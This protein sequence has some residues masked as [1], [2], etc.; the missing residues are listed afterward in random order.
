MP[1]GSRTEDIFRSLGR[2][3]AAQKD[4]AD[5]VQAI[6]KAIYGNGQPG[7]LQRLEAHSERLTRLEAGNSGSMYDLAKRYSKVLLVY[8][9]VATLT[10]KLLIF[11]VSHHWPAI[12]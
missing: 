5:A 4:S 2:I 9:G 6:K 1:A 10:I 8:G 11:L 12:P 7:I 3:E